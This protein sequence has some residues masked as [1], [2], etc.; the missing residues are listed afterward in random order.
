MRIYYLLRNLKEVI[1]IITNDPVLSV[2]KKYR[3]PLSRNSSVSA[4]LKIHYDE[5]IE[6]LSNVFESS[7]ERFLSDNFYNKLQDLLEMVKE[8][9]EGI[10]EVYR[11]YDTANMVLT[12]N[13]L[14]SILAKVKDYLYL[15]TDFYKDV[16]FFNY[17]RI[18][19]GDA[20][21]SRKD[22]FHVPMSKRKLIKPYRYSIAGYPCLY[23]S[24]SIELCWFECG[25][26]NKF[27]VSKLRAQS[28]NELRLLDFTMN[29]LMLISNV[30]FWYKNNPEDINKIDDYLMKY[31]ITYPL[32]AACSIKVKDKNFSFIEEYIFPQLLLI[33]IRLTDYFDGVAYASSSSID[34]AQEWN[35]YNVVLPAKEIKDEYCNKLSEMFKVTEPRRINFSD[36]IEKHSI[37]IDTVQI[38][39]NDLENI[40]KNECSFYLYREII[41]LCKSFLF[42][43]NEIRYSDYTNQELLYQMTDTLN[44][45]S[46]MIT[47]NRK[48][49]E[50]IA[51]IEAKTGPVS[52]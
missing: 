40:Y 42:L 20:Q 8:L 19:P 21:Y 1:K 45:F 24:D 47:K 52:I 16:K 3:L 38:F 5:Y 44:L 15:K 27:S 33:W 17:Y 25:M 48:K 10:I 37:K 39:L 32:R 51:I 26:P 34:A 14:D 7:S 6:S 49:F 30:D 31:I 12:Y 29:P 41:S 36:M 4:F 23:I 9:S 11:L 13:K 46:D 2:I 35:S 50:E 28:I 18:R 43:I 22:L